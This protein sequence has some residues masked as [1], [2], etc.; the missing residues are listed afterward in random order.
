MG[1][2]IIYVPLRLVR[3]TVN[4]VED[5]EVWHGDP[6]TEFEPSSIG[7]SYLSYNFSKF[8]D[9]LYLPDVAGQTTEK[10]AK[11]M[12]DVLEKLTDEKVRVE[13]PKETWEVKGLDG[14]T[15]TQPMDGWTHF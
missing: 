14:K 1:Y 3:K 4:A 6:Y 2:G 13:I 9:H 12:S 10:I 15:R 8:K 7:E 5:G 11:Q